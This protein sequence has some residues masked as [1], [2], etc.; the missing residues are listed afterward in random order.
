MANKIRFPLKM[1]FGVEVRTLE[2]LQDSFSL[3]RVIKYYRNGKLIT[4]LRARYH[5][6]IADLLEAINDNDHK[7]PVKFCEIFNIENSKEIEVEMKKIEI[8][9]RKLMKLKD[10]SNEETLL[11]HVD[12]IAFT[13]EDLINLL[14]EHS[15]IIYL[16]GEKFKIPISEDGMVYKG[17][18]TPLVEVDEEVDN[19]WYEKEIE[20][21]NVCYR[22]KT[23]ISEGQL[24]ELID[25]NSNTLYGEL[26]SGLEM[27][28]YFTDSYVSEL[29]T[30][31]EKESSRKCYY[32]LIKDMSHIKYDIDSDIEVIKQKLIN[33][34]LAGLAKQY[35][36]N[37]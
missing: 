15:K 34:G 24:V 21:Y 17:V 33:G 25:K 16:C 10:Y 12:D 26:M 29:L 13:Q 8:R 30:K 11:K 1:E 28:G 37:L 14:D 6:D 35:I 9:N 7:L 22:K 20:L 36:K 2:E 31:S 23:G 18:N 3:N 5:D 32:K 19:L 27:E 4:W